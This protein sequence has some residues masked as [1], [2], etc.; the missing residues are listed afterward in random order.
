VS[1]GG[2]LCSS[3]PRKIDERVALAELAH[4][5]RLPVVLLGQTLGPALSPDESTR[6]GEVLRR[7]AY[8]G[9]REL[10]S[11]GLASALGV[12]PE[13]LH[14][15][16]DDAYGL[17]PS[18]PGRERLA[19]LRLVED[20]RP[21]MLV[22]V[23]PSFG[24]TSG[25]ER[26]V[27]IAGQLD[28]LAQATG[29]RLLFAPHCGGP[30]AVE[31]VSDLAA[32]RRLARLLQAPMPLLDVWAPREVRWLCG[33]AALVV[34]TRYHPLVFACAGGVPALGIFS[35]E[36]TRVKLR[37]A[38]VHSGL[39]RWALSDTSVAEG[40]LLRRGLSLWTE[41]KKV[42]E[43]LARFNEEALPAG[44]R[45]Q[46]EVGR[47]LGLGPAE[48]GSQPTSRSPSSTRR[49]T[50]AMLHALTDVQWMSYALDGYLR[51]GRVLDDGALAALQQRIDDIMLGAVVTPGLQAQLDTGGAYEDLPDPVPGIPTRTL[52]YRKIQ[53][54][55]R[56]PWFRALL[57]RPLFRDIC[58]HEYGAHA[59]ISIFRAMVMN[60]PAG[61]GTVLPW[62]QDGGDVWK[63]DRDPVVTVWVALDPATRE[64]GCMQ[65]VPGTH[66][67]GVLSRFGSTISD[68]N[69]ARHCP[70]GAVEYLEVQAGE[71]VL[72]HNWLLHRSGVNPTSAP[73]RAFTACY[74]DAR[75]VATTTGA[76]FPVVFGEPPTA[77]AEG[78]LYVKAIG[79]DALRQRAAAA[80]SERYATSLREE[81]TRVRALR[82][83]AE[84][85]AKSLLEDN[86]R[87]RTM[88]E[89]A[90]RYAKSLE[91]ARGPM[92]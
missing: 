16:L 83:E 41:A 3:W 5:L 31:T 68:L 59:A 56:D 75:T 43:C 67:L 37:G 66:R 90:E 87:L 88:R 2:N 91:A 60:K 53:G 84:A 36:Y 49:N 28:A 13:R 50:P 73:R 39:E 24:A 47:A 46:A 40:L 9:V 32:G 33:K 51:L 64:N 22:T 86:G 34:S 74:M 76:L 72:L 57:Q 17:A 29:S 1:G 80:E 52:A 23:D 4:E 35:D 82:E 8:V 45:R 85:Y 78:H 92:V 81:N 61:Q 26:L 14:Y 6:L 20:P 10:D 69:V 89:E 21:L 27:R 62:H 44:A 38:L 48:A 70:A 42:R 12:D 55:E 79:D 58:A 11:L 7:A 15:Q 54:L 19:A 25:D 77:P 18:A 71:A 65:I 63:L 30:G